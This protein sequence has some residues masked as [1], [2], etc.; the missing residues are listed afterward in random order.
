MSHYNNIA[1]LVSKIRNARY[2]EMVNYIETLIDSGDWRDFTTPA[3]TRFR[4]RECEFDYFLLTT[5]TL[6][7]RVLRHGFG[8]PKTRKVVGSLPVVRAS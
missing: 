5:W 6:T 4:F 8:L 3:G 7:H 1:G 2:G